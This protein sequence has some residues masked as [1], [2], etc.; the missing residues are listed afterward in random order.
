MSLFAIPF[1]VNDPSASLYGLVASTCSNLNYITVILYLVYS[2]DF[3][4]KSLSLYFV[5]I[6][7]LLGMEDEH[8]ETRNDHS[9]S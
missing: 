6:V 7:R 8:K 5:V 4:F 9:G 3:S 2:Q 1:C